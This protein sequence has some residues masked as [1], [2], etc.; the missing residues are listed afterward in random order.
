MSANIFSCSQFPHC[1]GGYIWGVVD[2]VPKTNFPDIRNKTAIHSN[3]GSCMIVPREG[4]L[5]RL[6]LQL[7]DKKFLDPATGRVDKDKVS[8]E[9]L[10]E[11]AQK[12]FFPYTIEAVSFDTWTLY[13]IGQRV[14]SKFSVNDRIFIMGDA[15]HTHSPKAGQGMNASINDAHNLGESWPTHLCCISDL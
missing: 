10:M 5:V 9:K 3:N 6:Y 12:T 15:C 14:A 13:V 7:T 1:L 2:I 8:P 11:V 4:D